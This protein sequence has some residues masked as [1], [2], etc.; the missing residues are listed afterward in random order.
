MGVS[1]SARAASTGTNDVELGISILAHTESNPAV[2]R[3]EGR[4]LFVPG[5][6]TIRLRAPLARSITYTSG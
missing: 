6:F 1:Q 2:I 4:P 5:K 3:R